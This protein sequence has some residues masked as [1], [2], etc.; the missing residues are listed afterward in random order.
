MMDRK[1]DGTDARIASM[2]SKLSSS[3]GL[4][5]TALYAAGRQSLGLQQR[6][7]LEVAR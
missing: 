1:E 3:T 7:I 5:C 4:S 2:T 6:V